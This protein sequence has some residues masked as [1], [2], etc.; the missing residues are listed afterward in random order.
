MSLVTIE[1][2]IDHGKIIPREPAK[3][4]EHGNGLLTILSSNEPDEAP[5]KKRERI[6]FPLIHGKPGT[7]INPTPEDLD[8]SLWD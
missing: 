8:A 7:V 5:P 2:E 4:P 3:L 6:S 1:V